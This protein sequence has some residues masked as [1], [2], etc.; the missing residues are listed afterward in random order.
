GPTNVLMDKTTNSLI[1]CDR[2]NRRVI[3]QSCH[4]GITKTEI[5]VNDVACRGLAMDDQGLLY[6]ADYRKHVVKRYRIGDQNGTIVAGGNGKGSGLHQLNKPRYLFIDKQQSI[7]VSDS[8]NH[9][10]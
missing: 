9:R 3:R 7:Y 6:V 8:G 10:V 5:L 4:H 2:G 1:I